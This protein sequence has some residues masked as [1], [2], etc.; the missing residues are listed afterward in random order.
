MATNK[1]KHDEKTQEMRD[2]KKKEGNDS[3]NEKRKMVMNGAKILCKYMPAPGTLM[4]T[5]NQVK[6][7]D[8]LWATEG[9][10]TKMNLQFQG[11]CM[12][13]K[14]GYAKPPCIG[15]IVP[16]KWEDVGTT[17]VQ[18]KKV[19]IKGSTIKCGIS[20]EAIKI[21]FDGQISTPV[22]LSTGEMDACG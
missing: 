11:V 2:E 17:I 6:L 8:Q 19:L 18:D 20:N 4:V 9:D 13:P 3:P 12:H 5:S 15:V 16:T 22:S 14:W 7:Q 21:L 10:C 1:N